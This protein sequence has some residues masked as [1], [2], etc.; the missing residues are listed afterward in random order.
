MPLRWDFFELVERIGQLI[1]AAENELRLEQ[2][3]YGLDVRDELQLHLLLAER[4]RAHYEVAT[5]VHYPSTVGKKLTHRQRCDMVL[6]PL[7]RA[8]RLDSAPPSLFD[9][10]NP[11]TPEEGL[12]LEVKV[13]YQFREGGTRHAG[14]GAQW[15]NALVDD[16]RKMEAE[17][18]ICEAGLL[19]VVFNESAAIL[20][21]DLE[22]F[23]TILAQKEI[24]AGFRQVKSVEISD[25]IGHRLCTV[26]LWPIIQR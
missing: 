7:G 18:R 11:A 12:W 23:E 19:L 16:L 2:T 1:Q 22:L 4:L 10:A 5:E 8:L 25:R 6:T 14:Y 17:P 21:K 15:R 26:A 9:P 20:E 13:A 3:V 24:L